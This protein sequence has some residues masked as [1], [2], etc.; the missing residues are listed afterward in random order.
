[1]KKALVFTAS[2]LAATPAIAKTGH[3]I[4]VHHGYDCVEF[5]LW[6]DAAAVC[7][8]SNVFSSNGQ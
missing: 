7:G 3:V 5:V 4:Q 6:E 8:A 1:V 2:L